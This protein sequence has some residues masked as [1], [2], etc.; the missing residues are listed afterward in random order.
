MPVKSEH[1]K[2]PARQLTIV[3]GVE[4][5]ERAEKLKEAMRARRGLYVLMSR[6]D[7]LRMAIA[8]GLA[9]LEGEFG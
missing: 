1:I 5:I 6:T 7:V 3:I 9:K 4:A 2:R 8:E